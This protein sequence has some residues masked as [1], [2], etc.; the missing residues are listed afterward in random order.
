MQ[1]HGRA[2]IAVCALITPSLPYYD[3]HRARIILL[4]IARMSSL[5]LSVRSYKQVLL[6]SLVVLLLYLHAFVGA[7]SLLLLLILL[8]MLLFMLSFLLRHCNSMLPLLL[9]LCSRTVR[10]LQ[11]L[12]HYGMMLPHNCLTVSYPKCDTCECTQ[13]LEATDCCELVPCHVQC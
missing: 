2:G 8:S 4:Y 11:V 1:Y 9:L 12:T 5:L 10:M 7:T 3:S 6:Q 13:P